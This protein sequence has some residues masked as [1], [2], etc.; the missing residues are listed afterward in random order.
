MLE[1]AAT[2]AAAARRT[3]DSLCR[4]GAI[5]QEKMEG[6]AATL[7]GVYDDALA[8]QLQADAAYA[9]VCKVAAPLPSS[10]L[11]PSSPQQLTSSQVQSRPLFARVS[12]L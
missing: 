8:L 5:T 11:P 12:G 9:L 6:V 10:Q 3:H 2:A 4:A 1:D 7:A